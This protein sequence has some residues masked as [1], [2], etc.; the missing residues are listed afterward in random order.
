M[1]AGCL[2]GS[3]MVLG[4]SSEPQTPSWAGVWVF[5]SRCL[6]LFGWVSF[7]D[8]FPPSYRLRVLSQDVLKGILLRES[9][10]VTLGAVDEGD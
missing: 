3:G 5:E 9:F 4:R 6:Q 7:V 1:C 10:L 8:A 2:Q